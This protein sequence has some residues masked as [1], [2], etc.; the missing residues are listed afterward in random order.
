MMPQFFETRLGQVYYQGT[1]PRIARALERIANV[2]EIKFL[3]EETK[4]DKD[5]K[6]LLSPV[7]EQIEKDLKRDDA[8]A[9]C[10]LLGK[11]S[12]K[13]LTNYLPEK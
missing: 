5:Q 3:D 10:E 1:M 7:I 8:T 2:L 4:D 9:I 12:I 11:L 13:D 6:E